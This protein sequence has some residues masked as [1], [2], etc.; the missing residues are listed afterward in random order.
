MIDVK[1]M[2]TKELNTSY[3]FIHLPFRQVEQLDKQL[4]D[5]KSISNSSSYELLVEQ[6]GRLKVEIEG[7][8]WALKELKNT[9]G[10]SN[11]HLNDFSTIE[12]SFSE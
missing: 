9:E 8:M 5:Y 2:N 3:I 12:Y 11:D 4:A 1:G 6:Y 10:M 7:K